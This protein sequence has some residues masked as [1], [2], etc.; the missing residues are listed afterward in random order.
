LI[1]V[2]K[3]PG[4]YTNSIV[5]ETAKINSEVPD[6]PFSFTPPQNAKEVSSFFQ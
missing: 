3:D 2:D 6:R 5:Y 4:T 1:V